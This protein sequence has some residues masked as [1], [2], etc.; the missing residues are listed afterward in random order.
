MIPSRTR[1]GMFASM[2]LQYGETYSFS[3]RDYHFILIKEHRVS[4]NNNGRSVTPLAEPRNPTAF[5]GRTAKLTN[6]SCLSSYYRRYFLYFLSLLFFSS[7]S[8]SLYFPPNSNRPLPICGNV[9]DALAHVSSSTYHVEGSLV[10]PTGV[11]LQGGYTRDTTFQQRA[12]SKHYDKWRVREHTDSRPS[13][14]HARILD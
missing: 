14:S 12:L 7:L 4:G 10:G 6:V 11:P 3:T 5:S 9:L 13:L 8:L 2:H 1:F